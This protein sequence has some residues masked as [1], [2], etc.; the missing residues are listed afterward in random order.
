L[1]ADGIQGLQVAYFAALNVALDAAALDPLN[2]QVVVVAAQFPGEYKVDVGS[3][4][5]I[6]SKRICEV[7]LL[8]HYK[9]G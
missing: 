8:I 9:A 3:D 7:L 6:N 1:T 4:S 2:L 5:R